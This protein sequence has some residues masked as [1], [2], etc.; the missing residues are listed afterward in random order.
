MTTDEVSP[1]PVTCEH[2]RDLERDLRARRF[3]IQYEGHSW[4][5][6]SRGA[7]VYFSCYLEAAVIRAAYKLPGFVQY[8]EYDGRVGGQEAGFECTRCQSA[9]MGAHP[10]YRAEYPPFAGVSNREHR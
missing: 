9:V 1:E 10:S 4:W 3:P 8:S 7:W 6:E 5:G 2:L